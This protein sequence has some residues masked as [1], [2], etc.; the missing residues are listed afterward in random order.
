ML[1]SLLSVCS[2]CVLLLP[3]ILLPARTAACPVKLPET[4]LSLYRNSD[5][6]YVARFDR[7]DDYEIIENTEERTI[8]NIKKHFD[9]SSTLKGEPQKFVVLDELDHRYKPDE[10]TA[11]DEPVEEETDETEEENLFG[12]RTL[13]SGDLLLLFL[14][15]GDDGKTLELT[16]YRDAI[17]KMTPERLDSYEA[18][19]RDL[20]SI[21]SA[22]EVDDAAI[23]EWLVR[24]ARDP[25]TRWEGA[26]ELQQ[27]FQAL[28]WRK[29]QESEEQESEEE[30]ES[31]DAEVAAE[32]TEAE[33]ASSEN[34]SEGEAETE[35]EAEVD[36]SVYARLLNDAHK[37]ALMNIVLEP[38]SAA[39]TG[40][41]RLSAGDKVLID[42]VS[43]WGDNRFASFLLDRLQA[44]PDDTYFAHQIMA[45][46]STIL[47]DEDLINIASK[48][49]DVYYQDDA[50][51]V[52]AE[53][54]ESEESEEESEEAAPAATQ[55]AAKVQVEKQESAAAG[56]EPVKK[57]TY[58]ELR[59]DLVTK[60]LDRG[61]VAIQIA[62]ANQEETAER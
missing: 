37:Q 50:E 31:S 46:I 19:I 6:I 48:Y 34:E 33:V 56:A 1:K 18:R 51:V 39:E 57:L 49:E 25:V 38:R 44:S 20:N 43:S 14:K 30:A 52:E 26:F 55:P 42:V 28:E 35:E 12:A 10:D 47:K 61:F 41:D 53:E 4:L 36:N 60:F 9:I 11:E 32:T 21:F 24:C 29:Q 5:A 59:A 2:I 3:T 13:A 15:K 58:K 27:S 23:V 62:N 54:S 22:K 17:K 16:D 45:T 7:V 40:K 8:V